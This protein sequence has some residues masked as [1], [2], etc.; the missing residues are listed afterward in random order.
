MIEKEYTACIGVGTG[1]GTGGGGALG[2]C[3][4]QYFGLLIQIIYCTCAPRPVRPVELFFSVAEWQKKKM[5][6]APHPHPTY[7][8]FLHLCTEVEIAFCG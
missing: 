4:A 3:A 7:T 1:G 8:M 5:V 6:A 2:A